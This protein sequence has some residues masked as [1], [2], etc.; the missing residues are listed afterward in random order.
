MLPPSSFR[1]E[2]RARAHTHT[3]THTPKGHLA[4]FSL[5][6]GSKGP[7]SQE[8]RKCH[9][10][11]TTTPQQ[12]LFALS[13]SL[14]SASPPSK[15]PSASALQDISFPQNF[16]SV[17]ASRLS[18]ACEQV[19]CPYSRRN[20]PRSGLRIF[21][22][23]CRTS[24]PTLEKARPPLQAKPAPSA[25]LASS[26]WYADLR[27]SMP[28]I[29]SHLGEGTA[30]APSK[31]RAVCV[32]RLMAAMVL[33]VLL[34]EQKHCNRMNEWSSSTCFSLTAGSSLQLVSGLGV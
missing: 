28:H 20:R 7:C 29:K 13:S 17:S 34:L 16:L 11:S 10:N 14:T 2:M 3:H 23:P 19:V 32:T 9:Q 12:T 31:A 30:P 33:A 4:L 8:R 6:R 25:L 1:C 26:L 24:H 15:V 5:S 18:P 27:H 22:T 21:A